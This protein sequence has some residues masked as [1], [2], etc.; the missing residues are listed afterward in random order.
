MKKQT[1]LSKHNKDFEQTVSNGEHA[2]IFDEKK[3][4]LVQLNQL[5]NE[6]I[7]LKVP[8]KTTYWI[9]G[10]DSFQ[11]KVDKV[12]KKVCFIEQKPGNYQ[13]CDL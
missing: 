3:R 1:E 2:Q 10:L 11:A 7:N 4:L 12:L 13:Y 9:D 6:L 5:M 8:I